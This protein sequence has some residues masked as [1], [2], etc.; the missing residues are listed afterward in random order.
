MS[1]RPALT[2]AAGAALFLLAA[3]GQAANAASSGDI[4]VDP[5]GRIADDGTVTLSGT[6]RCVGNTDPVFVTSSVN[7]DSGETRYGMG[8]TRAVCDGAV[9]TWQNT[10]RPAPNTLKPGTAHVEAGLR[11]LEPNGGMPL[12]RFQ[13]TQEQDVVLTEG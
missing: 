9:H 12:P 8:V 11:E 10:G 2:A 4:T 7:Q 13:T 1:F 5:T 3:P 6:Y